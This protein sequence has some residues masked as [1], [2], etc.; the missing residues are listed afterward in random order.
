MEQFGCIGKNIFPDGHDLGPSRED[1]TLFL[2]I[3]RFTHLWAV[4]ITYQFAC[5]S[6]LQ[7]K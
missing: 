4:V 6:P 1:R 2:R 5:L 3:E 7:L